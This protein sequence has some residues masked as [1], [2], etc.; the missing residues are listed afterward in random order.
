MYFSA[1]VILLVLASSFVSARQTG[2]SYQI[3]VGL[4]FS[5]FTHTLPHHYRHF[6]PPCDIALKKVND[7]AQKGI[8]LNISI[9]YVWSTTG[10]TCGSPFMEAPGI[11]S[12]LYYEHNIMALFGPP[13]GHETVGA[14][15][16]A[17][18]WNIPILSGISTLPALDQKS[19]YKTLTRTSWKMSTLGNAVL[20]FF[21]DNEWTAAAVLYDQMTI[22]P[23]LANG[24]KVLLTDDGIK[25]N[26]VPL[27]N[28]QKINV[29]LVDTIKRGRSKLI[30]C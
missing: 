10:K 23:T 20:S 17:A 3:K 7:L 22:W 21:K 6:K 4:L 16:L 1:G 30:K 9:S 19:R 15:N 18:F 13:C 29:A 8:Y 26:Y 11:A 2:S 14:G 12:Q 28:Y 24:L 25:V 5:D 27:A